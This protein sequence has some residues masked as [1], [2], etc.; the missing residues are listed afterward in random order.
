MKRLVIIAGVAVGMVQCASSQAVLPGWL[1]DPTAMK[2][3]IGGKAGYQTPEAL[4]F[5]YIST[6]YVKPTVTPDEAVKVGVYVTDFEHSKI[7]L[8]DDSHR[9]T[10]FLEYRPKGGRPKVLTLKGLRSG[11]AEFSL[12]R[13]PVGEYE[14]RVWAIDAKGRES[15]RVIHD[16][17]VVSAADLAIPAGKVYK[18]TAADLAAYGIRNDGDLEKVVYVGSDGARRVVKEKRPGVPGYTVTVPLDPKTGKLPYRAFSKAEVVYDAGYDKDLVE[19]TAVAT[20]AGIQKLI[21]E[22]AAAGFRKLVMLPG[23]YR[24]SHESPI[25]MPDRFTWD[26]G[27]ATLKLNQFHGE[28]CVMVRM[29]SAIDA[30]VT[31]GAIEGDYWAHD[32][33]SPKD[34]EWV[35]GFHISGDSWYCSFDGV[36]IREIAGYGGSNH[37]EKDHRGALAFFCEALP[38]YTAGGLDRKTGNVDATD[39]HR[40]TSDFFD[41]G[42]ITGK[43]GRRRLQ[44]SKFLGYQGVRTRSWQVTVCWYDAA[45]EFLS[46]ETC[47]QYR[48][49]WIPEGA[50][51]MRVSVEAESL[52]DACPKSYTDALQAT[53]MRYP[54]NCAIRNCRFERCRCV[55][56][57]AAQMKNWI[58]EGNFFTESGEAEAKCAFDAEDGADQM[59]DV[60]FLRNKFRDNPINNSILTCAGHNFILEQN[61]GSIHFWGRTHSPCVRGNAIEQA[62]YYCDN[63]IRSGYGRFAG[64]TYSKGLRLGLNDWKDRPDNWDEVLSNETFDGSKGD[65]AIEVG[66]AGRLVGCVLK[67]MK[68]VG[69][70]NAQACVIDGCKGWMPRT[71]WIE[72]TVK[73]SSFNGVY[74]T[75][76]WK[77][78]RFSGFKVDNI[79]KGTVVGR[80]CEFSDSVL[81]GFNNGLVAMKDCSFDASQLDG[82]FFQDPSTILFRNCR[83]RTC[84]NAS[85]VNVG[86]NCVGRFTFD[87]CE[88]A[89]RNSLVHVKEVRPHKADAESGTIVLK[90]LKWKNESGE[91][92]T[93]RPVPKEA[94]SR[95]KLL[96]DARTS[97]LPPGV[98]PADEVFP[99]WEVR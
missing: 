55:G 48:E 50:A 89:G 88:V 61:D 21:D 36:T 1:T 92:V 6:Y 11:D 13:L 43:L 65:F 73:D 64:N 30:H 22:K 83:I 18:M 97:R 56:Y 59:Q 51:F 72:C 98:K 49:M 87:G 34:S 96:V 42:K 54:V 5:P 2:E 84:D 53:A 16:F 70:G 38:K 33:T 27:K 28:K 44:I 69:I 35:N 78:C 71:R 94:Y 76:T 77:N 12:G 47:W 79:G 3:A 10:A 9:F 57:A 95:K 25:L 52:E 19:S 46:A 40:Y 63:R 37:I 85:F 24:I 17:R 86:V 68:K 29:A 66:N 26:L 93:H 8:L 67:D 90:N 80:K 75:N 4:K 45:K 14:L 81:A 41:L 91:V 15:H 23:V 20:A 60:Y 58:F 82:G 39:A 31:G 99:T 74:F 62:T 7:R 32:Y